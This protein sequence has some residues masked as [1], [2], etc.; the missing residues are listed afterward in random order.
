MTTVHVIELISQ[1]VLLGASYALVALPIGLLFATTDTVDMAVGAYAVL[2]ASIAMIVDGAAGL[3]LG[4]GSA[5]VA[6][7]IVGAIA[8]R[9]NRRLGKVDPI[10]IV[11]M[12]FGASIFLESFVLTTY[13]RDA[14]LRQNFS[15]FWDLAGIRVNPQ[16][17]INL[18][19]GLVILG[20]L[21][22]LL[23]CTPFGR[24]MRA[25]AVNPLGALLVGIPVHR[26]WYATYLF[27][28]VL[29]GVAG[30]LILNT[31]GMRYDSGLNLTTTA[32]S[33][34]ILFGLHSPARVF[35]GGIAIGLAQALCIAY[36]P[37]AW[38]TAIPFVF[39]FIVLAGGARMTMRVG[40]RA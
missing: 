2:A 24:S 36:L 20:A 11:L 10:T 1:G 21:S 15:E 17:I 33:A 25:S 35:L 22:F 5:L 13:G 4:V 9:M 19:V 6:S 28:G 23:Y 12:T 29:A 26:I 39:I 37:A 34:A 16:A 38:A 32:F 27:G 30:V 18:A 3:L 14:I 40:D 31:S 8:L 7:A